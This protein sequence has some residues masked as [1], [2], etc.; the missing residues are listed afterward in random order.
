MLGLTI[1]L[2]RYIPI[3]PEKYKCLICY[4]LHYV[5]GIV[6]CNISVPETGIKILG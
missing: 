5:N 6:N 4:F 2:L 3:Y 1:N